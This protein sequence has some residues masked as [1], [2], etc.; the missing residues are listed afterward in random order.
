MFAILYLLVYLV[1]GTAI[2]WFLLPRIRLIARIYIGL[3]LGVI[4][5]MWLPALMAFFVRFSVTGHLLALL[6]LAALTLLAFAFRDKRSSRGWEEADK[7]LLKTLVWI[8]LP[9]TL[10]TAYLVTTHTVKPAAD[11]SYHVGQSTYGDLNL[12][13]AIITGLRNASFPPDYSIYPG[14]LLAYPFLTDSFS[15]SFMV[16]GMKLHGAVLI[17]SYLLLALVFCGYCILCDRIASRESVARL[18]VLL[19]FLNGGLGFLY[20]FDM[21]GVSLGS[22]AQNQLQSGAGLFDRLRNILDGYYTTPTNHAEQGYYN[23]RWSNVLCDMLVPQ[24]TTLGGWAMVLPCLYLLYDTMVPSRADAWDRIEQE[25]GRVRLRPAVLLGMMAGCL[26]MVHTH[27]FTALAMVS[28][29]WA[30][31]DITLRLASVKKLGLEEKA[32]NRR[33]LLARIAEWAVYAAC[34]A[35]LALPQL[36]LWTFSQMNGS[37]HFI[38]FHFNWVNNPNTQGMRDGYFWFY[39]KN[40]GIPFLMMLL[41]LLEKKPWR[42]FLASG[43]FVVFALAE[44]VQFQPNEYDNN[45]LF[46]IWYM[47]TALIAADYMM[48]LFDRLKGLRSRAVLSALTCVVLF[49]SAALSVARECVSDYQLFS[50]DAVDTARF[51]EDNTEEHA[52]FIT[53]TEH[54]NPVSSLAGRTIVCGPDL[55]L[56]WHGFNTYERQ[57]ELRAFYQDPEGNLDI[58]RKYQAG[59]IL[60]GSYERAAM[61]V[62]TGALDSRFDRIYESPSGEYVIYQVGE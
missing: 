52:V 4:L 25:T 40:I 44:L 28:F 9:L 57:D 59:Y 5:M 56:Y 50:P 27:S 29:G 33:S 61:N 55:W 14:E 21:L 34:A 2:A 7:R 42:R 16:L 48:E 62:N 23:L 10:L 58:L 31:Y 11:G 41:A 37:D 3:C 54:I 35:A 17:P 24:R 18:A 47:L 36:F 19:F 49:L 20:A 32:L 22:S 13:L 6:P 39:L 12:H 43:A 1:S 53:W 38:R 46:Y 45:K 60:V 8:A 26:P 30:L 51:I 15:T